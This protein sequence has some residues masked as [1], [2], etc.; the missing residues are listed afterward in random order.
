LLLPSLLLL[1]PPARLLLA[2]SREGAAAEALV[3]PGADAGRVGVA[4]A[5]VEPT[6]A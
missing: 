5:C 4:R 1:R 6:R 2:A 3:G